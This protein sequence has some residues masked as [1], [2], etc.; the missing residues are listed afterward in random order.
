[1][2]DKETIFDNIAKE[3]KEILR[4][5]K[6]RN[7]QL[8]R[9]EPND[10]RY[11]LRKIDANQDSMLVQI[12]TMLAE[13]KY[14]RAVVSLLQEKSKNY[15]RIIWIGTGAFG[16]FSYALILLAKISKIFGG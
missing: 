13:L 4:P 9:E 11:L 12:V 6:A 1:M 10:D 14:Q 5:L 3:A 2:H 8:R 15:D 16:V 7:K